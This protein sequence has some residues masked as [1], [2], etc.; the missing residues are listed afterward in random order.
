M[1]FAHL[2]ILVDILI[3]RGL[4]L[5]LAS[6]QYFLNSC[7]YIEI[8]HNMSQLLR[9]V[10]RQLH[11]FSTF[12]KNLRLSQTR[13][14][15]EPLIDICLEEV[16]ALD[17]KFYSDNH[18]KVGLLV[19]DSIKFALGFGRRKSLLF[20]V[21]LCSLFALILLLYPDDNFISV[22]TFDSLHLHNHS[23]YRHVFCRL[24]ISCQL[25]LLPDQQILAH[26]EV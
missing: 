15:F 12:L 10:K 11:L 21:F 20:H 3:L 19:I 9:K 22:F 6:F 18:I 4:R 14:I 24:P 8:E 2:H 25:L 1:H 26:K 5:K 13:K 23:N 17:S 16:Q 7:D